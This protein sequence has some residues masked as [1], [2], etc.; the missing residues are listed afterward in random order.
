M[1][2]VSITIKNYKSYGDYNTKIDLSGNN[3]KLIYGNIGAGKTTFVDAIIWCLYGESL[4]NQD[5]VINRKIKKNCKVEYDFYVQND[6]YSVSRYR[7]HEVNKDNLL[8]FKNH[9]NISPNKKRDAQELINNIV[10]INHKAMINSVMFSSEI[11][12]SFLR[13]PEGKRLGIIESV[14][15]LKQ[16]QKWAD[17]AK[18][19]KQPIEEE[20]DSAKDRKGKID[21]GVDILIKNREEYKEEAKQK[22]TQYKEKKEKA[23]KEKVELE[24]KIE[25]YNHIDIEQEIRKSKE[26]E[27]AKEN[28]KEINNKLNEVEKSKEELESQLNS[29]NKEY[30]DIKEKM[31]K[32]DRINI[33]EELKKISNKENDDNLKE[34]VKELEKQ[35]EDLVP[36]DNRLKD[37]REQIERINNELSNIDKNVCYTCGQEINKEKREELEDKL[38]K[39]KDIL[40]AKEYEEQKERG[41]VET[42][43]KE[44]DKQIENINGEITGEEPELTRE[45]IEE[46]R[47]EYSNLKTRRATLEEQ[48]INL[49]EKLNSL[50]EQKKELQSNLIEVPDT[51]YSMEFLENISN[52]I[53][54]TNEKIK[55]KREEISL[56]NETAKNAYSKEYVEGFNK[57]IKKLEKERE[58]Q[59]E[60]IKQKND[61]LY[62][63]NFL[64]KIFSNKEYGVK[65]FIVSKMI[66]LFNENINKYIPLF[67]DRDIRVEF[68]K[69]LSETITENKEEVSFNSFS[70]GEKTLLDVAVAFSLFM[71]VKTFFSSDVR[72]LVFD[73]ILDRNLDE[74]GINAILNII[75]EKAKNN[76]IVVI[77]HRGEYKESFDNKMLVY[78]E[79]GL[80]KV[81]NE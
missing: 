63:Y 20:L 79:D 50:Y 75:N 34:K 74:N 68:D 21:Y 41:R 33:G 61:E 73:E 2:P 7:K 5:E 49:N 27:E 25:E 32:L 80:S 64:L 37:I 62:Y 30:V 16:L 48:V 14:L 11:Y 23:E 29:K 28:N 67:F 38:K 77:S 31:E 36:I 24:G 10:G 39:E 40:S 58:K 72:F 19:L 69:N 57:K 76:S 44:I 60:I 51:N 46:T 47:N 6:Y 9:K 65:K 12:T 26:A 66:D 22:L 55:E 1:N 53:N 42:K 71:L 45:E 3:V 56:I 59:E 43:N 8:I 52:T 54:E 70:S 35:K 78:K 17:G 15:N 4:V 81:K 13:V 18:K